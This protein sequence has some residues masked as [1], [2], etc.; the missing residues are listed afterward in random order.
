MHL[1]LKRISTIFLL[2]VYL[3]SA[4]EAYQLLKLPVVFEHFKEHKAQ[5]KNIDFLSFIVLH[6]FRGNPKDADYDR[7]MQLPFKTSDNFVVSIIPVTIP[8]I[9]KVILPPQKFIHTSDYI[10]KNDKAAAAAHLDA[11]FQPPRV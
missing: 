6:Y 11:I 3:F 4:T 10:L 5:D 7:D 8:A 1:I 2:S 9:C